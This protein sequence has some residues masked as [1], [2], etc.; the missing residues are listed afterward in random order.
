MFANVVIS[1]YRAD[2]GKSHR[3][4]GANLDVVSAAASGSDTCRV[5]H[6]SKGLPPLHVDVKRTTVKG[7]L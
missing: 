6:W 1:N 5:G 3:D 2:V 7:G 4:E